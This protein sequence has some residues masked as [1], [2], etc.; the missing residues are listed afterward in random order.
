MFAPQ[1][2]GMPRTQRTLICRLLQRMAALP[3]LLGAAVMVANRQ[4]FVMW[5]LKLP[6]RRWMVPFLLGGA[7]KVV[8]TREMFQLPVLKLPQQRGIMLLFRGGQVV[9]E[10]VWE[11]FAPSAMKQ[12]RLMGMVMFLG[13]GATMMLAREKLQL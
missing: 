7:V 3:F 4:T 1:Q 11:T 13:L 10:T 2:A 9:M 12:W 6:Q 8:A 5:A